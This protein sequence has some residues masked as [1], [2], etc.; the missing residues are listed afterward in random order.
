MTSNVILMALVPVF[1][2]LLL[3]YAAGRFHV[4]DNLHV[5]ALNAL[6]MDF[7]LPASLFAATASASRREMI[8]QVPLF[9]VLGVT[10]LLLYLAWY[11]AAR[12]FSKVSRSEASL[13]ALTIGFPNLAGVGLPIMTSVVGP[14]GT[15]PVAVAL[16]AGSILISPLTLIMAEMGAAK[17]RG[18]EMAARQVLTAIRRA[19]TKP[20]VLAPALGILF[21]L[22]DVSLDALAHASLALIGSSAAGVALFLTGAI[23]SAQSFRLDWKIVAATVASDI[24]RPLLAVAVIRVIPVAPDAAKTAILLAAIPS[25]FFG[26][27]FAVNYRLDSARA[28]SMVIASTAFSVVTLAIAIAMLF[29]H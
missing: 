17:A 11:L 27:L 26:I 5:D 1:F 25:G 21:S 8:E 28:G 4:V 18:E 7:A 14:T 16:A 20:V 9:L 2:V 10:M 15:V 24:V 3:G 22:S 19:I 13:Q 23:L 29:P 6:V 12:R